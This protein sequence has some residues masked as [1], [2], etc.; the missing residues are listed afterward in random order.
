M[1]KDIHYNPR[2]DT[3]HVTFAGRGYHREIREMCALVAK[4]DRQ[5]YSLNR[6]WKIRHVTAYMPGFEDVVPSLYYALY[7]FMFQLELPI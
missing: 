3:A 2:E 4:E 7:P 5:F 1:V 6:S